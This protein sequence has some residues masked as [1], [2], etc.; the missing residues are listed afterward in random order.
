MQ[1][2]KIKFSVTTITSTSIYLCIYGISIAQLERNYSE[3][4]PA[5][6]RPAENKRNQGSLLLLKQF[7]YNQ[8]IA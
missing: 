7:I 6:A 8:E 5:H 2:C 3:V 4:L 1:L